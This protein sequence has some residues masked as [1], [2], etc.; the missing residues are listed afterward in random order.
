MSAAL[1]VSGLSDAHR[2][3]ARRVILEGVKLFMADPS[4]IHYT[5]GP[6]RWEGIDRKLRI[7]HGEVPTHGD[8]SSTH[9]FLVWNGLTHV[10]PGIADILN[11][12]RWRAG[13]TGT[14]A[15]HGKQVVHLANL[16][17]GDSVLY[18]DGPNFEHVATAIGG[19]RV[20]SHGGEAGPFLLPANYRPI[21]M[22]R[23]HI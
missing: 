16:K 13:F 19:G 8:C 17:V 20:F 7:A 10:H 22:M 5:Q 11:G 2:A 21:S 6:L 15:H 3:E 18:G 1:S 23:R 4:R 14:I 12:E 9:T